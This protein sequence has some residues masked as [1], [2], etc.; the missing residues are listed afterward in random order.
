MA[1]H[2]ELAVGLAGHIELE[3]I[4][5]SPCDLCER[6]GVHERLWPTLR[7]FVDRQEVRIQKQHARPVF[8]E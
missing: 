6:D 1:T 5:I 4:G 3:A 7:L 8:L 2:W